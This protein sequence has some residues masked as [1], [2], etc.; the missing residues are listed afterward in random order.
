MK[1]LP[2]VFVGIV[3]LSVGITGIMAQEAASTVNLEALKQE[4]VAVLKTVE[5][6][7]LRIQLLQTQFSLLQALLPQAEAEA[8][9]AQR[10]QQSFEQRVREALGAEDGDTVDYATMSLVKKADA[11]PPGG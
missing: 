3:C 11:K 4:R 6:A 8:A 9:E 2:F 10:Q 5:A 1:R 7:T